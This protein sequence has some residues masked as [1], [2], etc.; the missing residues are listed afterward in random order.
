MY[1]KNEERSTN[2]ASTFYGV[3]TNWYLDPSATDHIAAELNMLSTQNK[4]Y[5]Q[6]KV[7]AASCLGMKISYIVNSILHTSTHDIF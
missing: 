7:C 5:G 2:N 4:Y 3:D 1:F 6:D